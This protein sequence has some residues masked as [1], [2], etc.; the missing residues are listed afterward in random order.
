MGRKKIEEQFGDRLHVIGLRVLL[1]SAEKYLQDNPVA[2]F[3]LAK[4]CL[5]N[6]E[7]IPWEVLRRNANTNPLCSFMGAENDLDV[8]S[9]LSLVN[10]VMDS[11]FSQH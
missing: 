11:V 4:I 1:Q 9:L 7:V 10:G 2:V 3:L 8:W 6:S 5:T